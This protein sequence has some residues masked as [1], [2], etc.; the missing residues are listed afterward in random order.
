MS[1]VLSC[2]DKF[3]VFTKGPESHPYLS[4]LSSVASIG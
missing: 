1:T 3:L 4:S 2:P